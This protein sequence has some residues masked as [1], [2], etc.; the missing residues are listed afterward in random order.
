MKKDIIYKL[1]DNFEDFLNQTEEG[2]GFWLARDLQ[3]LLGYCNWDNYQN[4]ISKAKTTCKISCQNILDYF[5][6]LEK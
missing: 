1:T 5:P 3:H 4:V 6:T 2:I